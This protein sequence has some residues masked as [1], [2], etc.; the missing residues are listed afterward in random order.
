ML[1][2]ELL[3]RED[4][5]RIISSNNHI[6]NIKKNKSD[7]SRGSSDKESG[8]MRTRSETLLGRKRSAAG[9][10]GAWVRVYW[11]VGGAWGA[12]Q[13]PT[14]RGSAW[15]ACSE[16]SAGA[17]RRVWCSFWPFL[18]GFCSGLAVLSFYAFSLAVECTERWYPSVTG[19]VGVTAVTRFW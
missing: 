12:W 1:T 4:T 18:V 3:K 14:A 9:A 2:K 16:T 5:C 7:T 10:C 8:V 15:S 17:W 11:R 19:N 6:I 13:V